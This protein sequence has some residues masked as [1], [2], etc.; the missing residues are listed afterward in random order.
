MGV[1]TITVL[2]QSNGSGT[3]TSNPLYGLL[4]GYAITVT[5]NNTDLTLVE[6]TGLG[7]TLLNIADIQAG[8]IYGSPLLAA[9]G[10]DGAAISGQYLPPTLTGDRLTVTIANGGNAQTITV[11]LQVLS[12]DD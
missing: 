2:T 5:T 7:R 1:E 8:T 11:K 10:S 9:V 6:A 4:T 3:A 12:E